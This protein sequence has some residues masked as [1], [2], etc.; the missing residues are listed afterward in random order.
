V[1]SAEA[2]AACGHKELPSK[3]IE[4]VHVGAMHVQ[5]LVLR[6]YHRQRI[7]S[8]GMNRLALNHGEFALYNDDLAML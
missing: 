3:T 6:I 4:V 7:T 8:G 1:L 2:A 5:H